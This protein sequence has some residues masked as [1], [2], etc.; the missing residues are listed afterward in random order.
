MQVDPKCAIHCETLTA[1]SSSSSSSKLKDEAEEV[2]ISSRRSV[3]CFNRLSQVDA[4]VP[5]DNPLSGDARWKGL[6]KVRTGRS[7][8]TVL[9]VGPI[10]ISG[11]DTDTDSTGG[12]GLECESCA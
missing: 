4:S 11:T 9:P 8:R 10:G 2:D 7:P 6:A 5:E 3:S 1:A 12:R